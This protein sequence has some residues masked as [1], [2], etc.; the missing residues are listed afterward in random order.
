MDKQLTSSAKPMM[1]DLIRD[2]YR[3]GRDFVVSTKLDTTYL[4]SEL[5]TVSF[6]ALNARLARD[7]AHNRIFLILHTDHNND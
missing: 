1:V 6:N 3:N 4:L 2:K 5:D 7:V